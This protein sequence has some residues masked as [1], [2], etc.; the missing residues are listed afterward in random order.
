MIWFS[1]RSRV[2][3]YPKLRLRTH[4]RWVAAG[5]IALCLFGCGESSGPRGTVPLR[6]TRLDVLAGRPG[7]RGWVDGAL[8][9]AHFEEPWEIVGDGAHTSTSPIPTSS[10]QST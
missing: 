6:L 10:A 1:M 9:F 4:Q 8:A 2:R 5:W 7:G 3:R